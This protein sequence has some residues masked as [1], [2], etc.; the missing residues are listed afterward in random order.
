[1][2]REASLSMGT[3]PLP[4]MGIFH[5]GIKCGVSPQAMQSLHP[6]LIAN[7]FAARRRKRR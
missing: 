4:G 3:D 7:S 2:Y 1:M 6:A 5:P